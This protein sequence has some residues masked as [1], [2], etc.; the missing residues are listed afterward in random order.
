MHLPLLYLR[1]LGHELFAQGSGKL[2]Q[3][4]VVADGLYAVA[5][6]EHRVARRNVQA[7]NASEH[8]AHMNAEAVTDVQLR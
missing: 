6:E 5:G 1:I 8:T 3:L 2:L 7:L 4:V